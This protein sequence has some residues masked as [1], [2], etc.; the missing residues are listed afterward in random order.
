M[1]RFA[2]YVIVNARESSMLIDLY[3][4]F[5]S[6]YELFSTLFYYMGFI[7]SVLLQ[8][9]IEMTGGNGESTITLSNSEG[10]IV[11]I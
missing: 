6:L 5:Y 9:R 4:L 2:I 3:K 1:V 7:F 8:K 10:H 11:S